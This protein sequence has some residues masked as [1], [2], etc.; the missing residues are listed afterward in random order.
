MTGAGALPLPGS[1]TLANWARQLV[2][3]Q[4]GALW[5]GHLLLHRVEAL[6]RRT[7]A[8]RTDPLQAL[9]LRALAVTPGQSLQELQTRLHLD[10]QLLERLLRALE[11]AGL[12]RLESGWLPTEPGRRALDQGTQEHPMRER[13]VF[14]FVEDERPEGHP[15]FLPL[16]DPPTLPWAAPSEWRFDVN[17][18]SACLARPLEWKQRFGFPLDVEALAGNE[19]GLQGAEAWRG[20]ILDRPERMVA[21]LALPQDGSNR[22]LGFAAQDKSWALASRSPQFTLTEGWREAFPEITVAMP[23]PSWSEAWHA[24]AQ[25]HSWAKGE[26]DQVQL[27][28]EGHELQATGPAE[29]LQ[30]LRGEAAKGET[31][32]LA[33]S[34][35]LKAAAVVEV[36]DGNC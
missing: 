11:S 1:R 10:R 29:L 27:R 7:L 31:W 24:W 2:S 25:A 14:Y 17:L 36:D 30:R 4:P 33:G 35:R 34:G 9:V 23:V 13:R 28:L 32:L 8:V 18:L 21:V 22:L 20:V 6:V 5:V 19:P 12:A 3:W 16:A 15:H 26:A